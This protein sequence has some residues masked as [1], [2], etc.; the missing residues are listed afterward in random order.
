MRDLHVSFP[1]PCDAPW[2][3]MAP[4]GC[5]RVCARCDKVIHD[6]EHYRLDEVQ[7]MLRRDPDTCVRARIGAD[8]AVAL[9]PGGRGRM[10]RAA[11]A[12]GVS[13]GLLSAPV[14]A[15]AQRDPRTGIIS[16]TVGAG[17]F[18][19]VS[20]IRVTVTGPDGK[21]RHIW[22]KDGKYRI[23][24]LPAGAYTLTF[25]PDCGDKWTVENVVVGSGHAVVADT[26]DPN[27]CIIIGQLRIEEPRA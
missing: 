13:A 18:D 7:A 10:L 8:G 22:V 5:D 19:Y 23:D 9:K 17:R 25:Y 26:Q 14:P 11:V 4:A 16:G 6:L 21:A 12:A 15:S 27:Q 20:R 24:H 3:A 2:E 1:K